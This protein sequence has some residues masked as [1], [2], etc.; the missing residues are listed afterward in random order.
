MNLMVTFLL[1][2]VERNLLKPRLDAM[3]AV[4]PDIGGIFIPMGL[5]R[6]HVPIPI[7]GGINVVTDLKSMDSVNGKL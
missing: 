1:R 6:G 7:S 3:D 5:M 2:E 4:A